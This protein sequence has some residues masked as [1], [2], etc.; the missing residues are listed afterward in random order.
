VSRQS[1]VSFTNTISSKF[2]PYLP[3]VLATGTKAL[4]NHNTHIKYTYC[5]EDLTI[6]VEF[7]SAE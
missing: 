3:V 2:A 5:K 6:P 1:F 4:E 7:S